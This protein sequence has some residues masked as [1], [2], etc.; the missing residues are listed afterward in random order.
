M[1]PFASASAACACVFCQSRHALPATAWGS[2]AKWHSQGLTRGLCQLLSHC[3]HSHL[4]LLIELHFDQGVRLNQLP[5]RRG[6][7]ALQR[8][9]RL[10][11][12]PRNGGRRGQQHWVSGLS[13]Y[14][15]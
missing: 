12:P 13:S 9:A 10:Q 5:Q 8:K 4:V 6:V 15:H 7:T 2:I 3:C 1:Q 11:V 14:T